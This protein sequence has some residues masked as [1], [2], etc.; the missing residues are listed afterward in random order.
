MSDP[1]VE[2]GVIVAALTPF[3][4]QST[5]V[6]HRRF[7]E[8]VAAIAVHAPAA[9]GVAGVESQEFQ[10][11][12]RG[13]RLKL[14]ELAVEEAAGVPVIAGVSHASLRESIALAT[15]AGQRGATA[16]LAVANGKPWGSAPTHDEAVE[17]FHTLAEGSPLPVVLY[18]NPRLG[19]DLAVR[20]IAEIGRH[21]NVVAM[22]ETSRDGGKLLGLLTHAAPE[23]AVF[24]NMEL[25]AP[26]LLLGGHGAML[27]PSGL[28]VANRVLRAA[29]GGKR[30]EL[31]RL[32]GFFADFPGRWSALGFLPAVK[33]ASVLMGLPVGDPLWPHHAIEGTALAELREYLNA[34]GLLDVFSTQPI[35]SRSA[36]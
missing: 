4:R 19:V 12:G 2:R 29:R 1:V 5:R 6:D 8:Q 20:T 3:V 18:N 31:A 30:T 14:V 25:L 22:K 28:P 16:V 35:D 11:L 34:W 10:V 7:S 27:P 26:T 32:S 23:L 17:W 9:I 21:P 36:S 24:T 13:A 15:E 33:A